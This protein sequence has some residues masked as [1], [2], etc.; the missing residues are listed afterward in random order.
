MRIE[1]LCLKPGAMEQ[2]SDIWKKGNLGVLQ[3]PYFIKW[4]Q[5]DSNSHILTSQT[6]TQPFSQTGHD[7]NIHDKDIQS[8]F[9]INEIT[10]KRI[11]QTK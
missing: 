9:I 6:N 2:Q 11:A 4:Q 5:R 7:D 10:L 1:N 3:R 8:Y